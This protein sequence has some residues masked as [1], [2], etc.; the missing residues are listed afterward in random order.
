[1]RLR[2]YRKTNNGDYV[3]R[4]TPTDAERTAAF[5]SVKF[6]EPY[7]KAMCEATLCQCIAECVRS[8]YNG[9]GEFHVGELRFNSSQHA[10]DFVKKKIS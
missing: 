5:K 10:V 9:T 1:M 4:M 3:S 8:R 6:T 2:I 7:Y